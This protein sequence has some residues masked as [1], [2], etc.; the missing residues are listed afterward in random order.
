MWVLSPPSSPDALTPGA[1]AVG[2]ALSRL[3]EDAR[4]S[5]QDNFPRATWHC[6]SCPVQNLC[7][8]MLNVEKEQQKYATRQ[9]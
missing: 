4:A 3:Q 2:T 8:K 5:T 9:K 1:L 7:L 6:D